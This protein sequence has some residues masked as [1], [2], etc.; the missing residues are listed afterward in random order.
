[1]SEYHKKFKVAAVQAVPAF[2]D[3][4]AGIEKA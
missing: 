4:D 2:L 3:L 1:M